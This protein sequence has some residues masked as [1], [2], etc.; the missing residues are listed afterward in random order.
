NNVTVD[1]D[2]QGYFDSAG[3]KGSFALFDNGHG[4]FT[5]Y[6]LSRYTDSFY[7][8]GATFDILQSLIAIQMGVVK[9]DR[10]TIGQA[11]GPAQPAL[12]GYQPATLGECFR[13]S[14]EAGELGFAELGTRE[15]GRD[16]LRKWIDSLQYGNK[17]MGDS[18]HPLFWENGAL[19]INGDQQLGLLK[20]LYF[21]QLPF[22]NRTQE[23]VRDMFS[24]EN[25][26]AYTFRYKLAQEPEKRGG[27]VGW[28]MG[29][30]EENKHP[31][32][33]VVNLESADPQ[34]DLRSTGLAIARKILRQLGFF[35]GLK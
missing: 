5:I 17:N 35:Q 10:A 6:N 2:L 32:F 28:A 25:T 34:K 19:T 14:G 15:L 27:N 7:T 23:I 13:D 31:Y 21:N 1:K 22:F 30:V 8:P 24:V 16:T 3:V 9:D 26:S 4:H 29:W 11:P 12:K 18:S 20:K 33:F